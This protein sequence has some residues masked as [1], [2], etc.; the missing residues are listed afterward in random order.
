VAPV[1]VYEPAG[2][3]FANPNTPNI[4]QVGQQLMVSTPDTETGLLWQMVLDA[5]V[6]Q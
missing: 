4:I 2:V 6:Q 1:P 3:D 5:V